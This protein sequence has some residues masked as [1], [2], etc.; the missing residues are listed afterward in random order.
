MKFLRMTLIT[1]STLI[2]NTAFAQQATP[3]SKLTY[4]KKSLLSKLKPTGITYFSAVTGPSIG[5]SDPV[6]STGEV[7]EN[8]INTWNQISLQWKVDKRTNFVFNPR[9]S[10]R[11]NTLEQDKI[12]SLDSVIGV[13]RTWYK[14]DDGKLSFAG[15]LNTIMPFARTQTTTESGLIFNPGGFNSLS[16]TINNTLTVG[17]WFWGRYYIN[18]K[19]NEN[20]DTR[21]AFQIIPRF[22]LNFSDKFSSTVFYQYNG[23]TTVDNTTVIDQS[24]SLNVMVGYS[25]NKLITIQPMITMFRE[26]NFNLAKSNLNI[27]ISGRLF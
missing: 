7:N 21:A 18:D 14:S 12:R 6:S 3:L 8:S 11:H 19:S 13:T 1:M 23:S 5:G 24:D 16:Y 26:T 4:K 2:L 20:D 10:L 25:L 9:F 27:W 15:G 17:S 22:D